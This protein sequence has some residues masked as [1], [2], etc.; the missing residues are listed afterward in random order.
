MQAMNPS[1]LHRLQIFV[2]VAVG[3]SVFGKVA[4]SYFHLFAGPSTLT[5]LTAWASWQASSAD[6]L[7]GLQVSRGLQRRSKVLGVDL[8]IS[9]Y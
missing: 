5:R 6:S 8:G 2:G 7:L 4:P 3:P 9:F 1:A